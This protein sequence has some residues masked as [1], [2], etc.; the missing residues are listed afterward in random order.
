[1]PASMATGRAEARR[2]SG[3]RAYAP[4]GRHACC[5]W[6]RMATGYGD[7]RQV[8]EEGGRRRKKGG[9]ERWKSRFER[10]RKEERG[11]EDRSK[12]Q[13]FGKELLLSVATAGSSYN[14]C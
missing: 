9:G 7:E 12:G 5:G 3:G 11:K 14:A 8:E 2:R 6:R 1:M 13:D 4:E 10:K